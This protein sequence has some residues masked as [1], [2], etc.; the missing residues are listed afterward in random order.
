MGKEIA[1]DQVMLNAEPERTIEEL[2]AD[3]NQEKVH[4]E[5]QD[6]GEPVGNEKW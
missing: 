2:F 3:C 5:L 1:P 4:V 6:L